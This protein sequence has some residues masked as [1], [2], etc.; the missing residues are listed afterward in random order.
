MYLSMIFT[1]PMKIT[2]ELIN[3]VVSLFNWKLFWI[4]W[5]DYK[6]TKE[7]FAHKILWVFYPRYWDVQHQNDMSHVFDI[8]ISM[9][10]LYQHSFFSVFIYSL[11]LVIYS[12][13]NTI[14]EITNEFK[15]IHKCQ[16]HC[17]NW[18]QVFDYQSHM[19]WHYLN[20]A[21]I[22]IFINI[23]IYFQNS[24]HS[25]LL[26][27]ITSRLEISHSRSAWGKWKASWASGFCRSFPLNCIW[28]VLKFE[29][30]RK[31]VLTCGWINGKYCL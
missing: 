11:I 10:K 15:E 2:F 19:P 23:L 8:N 31:L 4:F 6:R 25:I 7:L 14:V 3:S 27:V 5:K 26:R 24:C 16:H 29:K 20:A 17:F 12:F 18:G 30:F 9:R 28:S 1:K 22:Y 21:Y 13:L